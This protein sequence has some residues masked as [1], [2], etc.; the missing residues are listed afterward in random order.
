MKTALAQLIVSV[1]AFKGMSAFA[2]VAAV[3]SLLT[4]LL[5]LLGRMIDDINQLKKESGDGGD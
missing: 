4:Q 1:N 2:Q 5:N 3:P